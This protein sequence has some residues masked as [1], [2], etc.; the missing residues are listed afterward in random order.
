MTIDYAPSAITQTPA[1]G[2]TLDY[3]FYCGHY[4]TSTYLLTANSCNSYDGWLTDVPASSHFLVETTDLS[5]VA[6]KTVY[7]KA[8][9]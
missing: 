7:V 1:C 8:R 6:T 2:H 3:L 5:K 4:R 9:S